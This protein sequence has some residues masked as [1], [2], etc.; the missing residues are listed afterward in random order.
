MAGAKNTSFGSARKLGAARA[1]EFALVDSYKLGYRN[2]EDVTNLPAGVLI[3]GSQNVQTNV[4]ERV[5]IR[6]GYSLDGAVSSLAAPVLSS[7]DFLTRG[8]GEVHLRAGGLTSAGNDGVLQYR[9]IA[10]NGTVSWRNLI[11]SLT[12]VAYNFTTFWRTDESLRVALFVNGAS[13]IQEWNGATTTLLSATSNTITKA[14]T[15]SWEDAGFYVSQ[16]GRSVVINGNVYTYTGG[17]TTTTLTG[18]SG[19]PAA[20]PVGSVIHQSV[21]TTLNS[22]MSGVTATFANGLIATMNNQVFL[23]SLTSSVEWLSKVNSYTDYTGSTPRQPGEG[24]SLILDQNLIAFNVQGDPT[25][26]TM[27]VSA[28]DVWY[29]NTFTAFTNI[30]ST[31]GETFGAVA[32]KTGRQ[33]GAQSQA[34]VSSMKNDT[35]AVSNEPTIDTMGVVEQYLTQV[36]TTNLSDP[37][38]LDIDGYDFTDGSIF[39]YRYYILVAVPKEGVVRIY[40]LNTKSWEAP[41]TLPISRFYIVDGE[42]YGHSYNTFESYKLFDGYADRVYPGF[43]GF[44]I[45]AVW[46]FSYQNYGSRHSYK[47][48]NAFYIEGYINPNTTLTVQISYELDGCQT[49]RTM[50]LAGNNKQ[51]VCI[52]SPEGSLGQESIGKIKLGGDMV[53]S[54][55]GLPPK[56]RWIPTF[57]N[58]DFFEVN[59]TFSVLGV[60][61]R[62]ELLAFGLNVAG[63]TQ[64][65]VQNKQ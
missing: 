36:Q 49:F 13:Q 45:A 44:P 58:K 12:S 4:S 28:S 51:F 16:S 3:V 57:G 20:E 31:T 48:A 63:S 9:Y 60:N 54:I 19:S 8:N 18:V 21:V 29:K 55:Q 40:D 10:T 62:M 1:R 26:P 42:L 24:G 14:G 2:R 41:Q 11:A 39:Y 30:D 22:S 46:N 64:I 65:P 23:G 7:F 38:K 34:M 53:A 56:F 61:Q 6:Q 52:A 5:Q 59:F 15:D 35:I 32:I 27:Y 43:T 37:I 25:S 47:S 17:E 50:T 33:Q